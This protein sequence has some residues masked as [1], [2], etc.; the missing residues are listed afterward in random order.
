[1]LGA[2]GRGP[3]S[4]LLVEDVRDDAVVGTSVLARPAVPEVAVALRRAPDRGVV[5]EEYVVDTE[6]GPFGHV[7]WIG[8]RGLGQ[9]REEHRGPLTREEA[10][11]LLFEVVAVLRRALAAGV[12]HGAL[13]PTA[14]RVEPSGHLVVLGFRG[15]SEDG[16]CRAVAELVE[17][18]CETDADGLPEAV[19]AVLA[20]WPSTLDAVSERL[21]PHAVASLAVLVSDGS[22]VMFPHALAGQVIAARR[23]GGGMPAKVQLAAA[24]AVTLVLGL[25]AGWALFGWNAAPT[26]GH[27]VVEGAAEIQL[28]CDPQV[29]GGTLLSLDT[30]RSCRVTARMPDGTERVG[31]LD[32]R[33]TG[34]YLCVGEDGGL[35]CSEQ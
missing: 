2:L 31:D 25:F 12:S 26:V 15:G 7:P 1:M 30:P 5:V 24:G 4:P 28:D 16:D 20:D 3:G 10:C 17:T 9:I 27:V 21:A 35:T 14:V 32:G 6:R 18:L 29:H 22:A 33:A 8:G 11:T 19:E 23:E 13:E 34:R